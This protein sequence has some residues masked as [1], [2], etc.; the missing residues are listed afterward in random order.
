MLFFFSMFF[1]LKMMPRSSFRWNSWG[2]TA[3]RNG[4]VFR[5]HPTLLTG[6]KEHLKPLP[7]S[8]TSP[9][10]GSISYSILINYIP[11]LEDQVA[12][13]SLFL[14]QLK[15]LIFPALGPSSRHSRVPC[16]HLPLVLNATAEA[17]R[18]GHGSHGFSGGWNSPR[19]ALDETTTDVSSHSIFERHWKGSS[20]YN[21]IY[22]DIWVWI[23]TY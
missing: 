18:S 3:S 9:P 6:L 17:W 19:N 12:S 15:L 11:L 7:K 2:L 10:S 23:N 21:Y 4:H 1:L 20:L 14:L 13:G 22:R 8:I 5:L 16:Q